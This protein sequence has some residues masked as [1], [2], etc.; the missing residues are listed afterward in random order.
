[1]IMLPLW[2]V[3]LIFVL[4]VLVSFFFPYNDM[5]GMGKTRD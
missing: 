1:M 2:L 5:A 4:V 3:G